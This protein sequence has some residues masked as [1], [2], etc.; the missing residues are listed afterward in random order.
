MKFIIT[1]YKKKSRR[2]FSAITVI[3]A[4]RSQCVLVPK[5]FYAAYIKGNDFLSIHFKNNFYYYGFC[6]IRYINV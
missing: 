5:V 4:Y 2:V 6:G 3:I 1:C